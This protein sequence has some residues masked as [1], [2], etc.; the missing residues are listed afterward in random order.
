MHSGAKSS[1]IVITIGLVA[2]LAL[3]KHT[4]LFAV[5]YRVLPGFHHFRVP[6]KF[7]VQALP[8]TAILVGHGMDRVLRGPSAR[9]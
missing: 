4:P 8:F 5:L 9:R 7:M 3:G 2:V 1:R 6:A